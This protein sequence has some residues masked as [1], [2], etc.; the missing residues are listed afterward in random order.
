MLKEFGMKR[1]EYNEVM[2]IPMQMKSS[3]HSEVLVA[4]P[5]EVV[6]KKGVTIVGPSTQIPSAPYIIGEQKIT[7]CDTI[8]LDRITNVR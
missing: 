1:E 4:T 2:G 6:G 5:L 8:K 3:R 7:P